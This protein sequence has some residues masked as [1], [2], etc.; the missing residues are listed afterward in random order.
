M[1]KMYRINIKTKMII[2]I[3]PILV[4]SFMV[5]GYIS[6]ISTRN[7]LMRKSSQLIRYK[8]GQYESYA[9]QQW[10]NLQESGL[11]TDAVYLDIIQDS[12]K[13]YANGMIQNDSEYI[14]ALDDSGQLMFSTGDLSWASHFSDE[15]KSASYHKNGGLYQF[16]LGSDS[17]YGLSVL[18]DFPEW[19]VYLIEESR[20]FK[21]DIR[22]ITIQ[23]ILSF[24]IILIVIVIAIIGL[25]NTI[26]APIQRF[27]NTIH[28]IMEN[29]DFSQ[30][31][32]IEYP[33]EIGD[34]AYDFNTLISNFD[35]AYSNLKEYALNE[36]I[37]LKELHTRE[38]ETLDVLA[39]ASDYKDPETAAHIK[40]VSDYALLFAELLDLDQES[41]DLIYY[42]APLHDVG[43]LG[44][45]DSILL[46]P[47]KLNDEEMK[48]MR[49]HTVIGYEIM[50]NPSSKFL[51]AGAI[52]AISHHERF[53][54]MGY[55]Y[56]LKGEDI[57]LFGRIVS[58]VDVFDALTTKRPYKDSWSYDEAVNEI[59][60]ESGKHFDP[61]LVQIFE[62]NASK[63]RELYMNR[64]Y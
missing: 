5:V 17:Y 39:R 8:A 4:C 37:V 10:T 6:V 53:D 59:L 2:M 25:L 47:G 36:A 48:I 54:G 18:L 51:K 7:S 44:I 43:K 24:I 52:I 19:E 63:F 13:N 64:D 11:S 50:Q 30:K 62:N 14:L 60:Q 61:F 58:I 26:T 29:K 45:P 35:L 49:N 56:G 28:K 22:E 41:R 34:L 27:R 1:T 31:V 33:D 32:R 9:K 16:T 12:L 38:Y 21:D 40:R 57:P 55:P 3:I 20:S 46:K 42:A 23:Q 15:M